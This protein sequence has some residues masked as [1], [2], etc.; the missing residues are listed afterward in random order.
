MRCH[1]TN[2]R[3]ALRCR[4]LARPGEHTCALHADQ[5]VTVLVELRDESGEP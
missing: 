1:G 4:R 3:Y 5:D 2:R